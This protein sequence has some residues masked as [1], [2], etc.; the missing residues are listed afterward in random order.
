[1]T[2]LDESVRKA[3]PEVHR[4]ARLGLCLPV[5]LVLVNLLL[6]GEEI[7][8]GERD[9]LR[10]VT[11]LVVRPDGN[12]GNEADVCGT[13]E[14]EQMVS[15]CTAEWTKQA[16]EET[17]DAQLVMKVDSVKDVTNESQPLKKQTMPVTMSATHEPATP[18][19]AL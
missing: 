17:G 9:D 8:L 14:A 1:M 16:S 3:L 4:P 2:D 11:N 19:G 13:T 12:K 5:G 15:S 10:V 18:K 6:A 7:N